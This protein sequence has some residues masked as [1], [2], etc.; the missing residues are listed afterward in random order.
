MAEFNF[1]KYTPGA[2]KNHFSPFIF[3]G[4]GVVNYQPRAAYMGAEYDLRPLMTEGQ[5]KPYPD[6]ALVIP[7]GAGVKYNFGGNWNIMASLGYRYVRSDYIDDVSGYYAS[8]SIFNDPV[9]LALSD[10]SGE[11]T[12]NYIGVAGT[13]RGDFRSHDT[14]L[15]VGLTLSY[16]FV[17]SNC[18][19]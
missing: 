2:D 18:Y 16:T 4:A 7:Y 19:Y 5:T 11:R 8:K 14:Y 13:Q 17:T 9:A 3:F 15:F 1:M 10:R 12:G 6:L